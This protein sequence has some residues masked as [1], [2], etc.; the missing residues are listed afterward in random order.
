MKF[1]IQAPDGQAFDLEAP[2]GTPADQVQ[3]FAAQKISEYVAGQKQ[4]IAAETDAQRARIAQQHGA[5]PRGGFLRGLTDPFEGAAQLIEH[6]AAGVANAIAPES[7]FAKWL[8]DNSR[9]NDV[10]RNVDE[11]R[12][13]QARGPNAGIDLARVAGNIVNPANV[14][15]GRALVGANT[16]RQLATRGAAAGAAGAALQP[17]IGEQDQA[18]FAGS[19]GTQAAVGA[20][21]GAILTP[22]VAKAAT[23]LATAVNAVGKRLVG[24][25]D[26]AIQ[27]RAAQLVD[28]WART[29][30]DVDLSAFP[31]TIRAKVQAQVADALRNGR[32]VDPAALARAADFEALGI[33]PTQGQITRNPT[34]FARERNLRGVEGAGEPLATRFAEQDNALLRALNGRASNVEPDTAGNQLIAALQ[35]TDEP[36]RKAVTAAYGAARNA[37]GKD[38]DLWRP[39]VAQS[40]QGIVENYGDRVP[41][42]VVDRLRSFGLIGDGTGK[43]LLNYDEADKLLKQINSLQGNDKATNSALGELRNAIKGAITDQPGMPGDPYAGAR[44]LAAARFKILDDTPGLRAALEGEVPDT[45]VRKYLIG[46]DAKSANNLMKALSGNDEATDLARGQVASFLRDK[47]FGANAAGDKGFSQE[48]F[49]RALKQIGRNKLEAIF[50]PQVADELFTVGR[51][52]AYIH[53]Q[54]AGSAVNNSN[55]AGA[56]MNLLSNLSGRAGALPV[57]NV[58]RDSFRTYG[59]ERAAQQALT[60]QIPR[61]L[62]PDARNRLLQY[63]AGPAAIGSG[64]ALGA[65]VN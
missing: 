25:S 20:A 60:G 65:A 45:F 62:S 4:K 64:A 33:K 31:A 35:A 26:S 42:A 46:A 30:T 58:V 29:Q 59:N 32:Q 34:Q 7:S 2:D 44:S 57:V 18:N 13:E 47:A 28:D 63:L 12:Y 55:T 8:T 56:V 51:V 19:K 50:G 5:T 48:S 40:V 3:A 21:G 1:R 49:N 53:S 52:G 24:A 23:G 37:A 17:V 10:R 15:G 54:P 22:A 14:A 36:A 6:G 41:S 11:A 43:K 39:E 9:V 38:A 27:Q 16:V 61:E